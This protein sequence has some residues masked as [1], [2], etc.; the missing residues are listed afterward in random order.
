MKR[1]ELPD[2]YTAA[3]YVVDAC[4]LYSRVLRDCLLY[5]A[6]ANLI[7]VV[8][9]EVILEEMTE[10]LMVNR[11]G[12]TQES[13]DHLARAMNT[14]YP[15]AQRNPAAADFEALAGIVLPDED[16]R[17]VI[18]TALG[19]PASFVCTHNVSDFPTDVMGR[20]N[21]T[22]LTPDDLLCPLIRDHEASM[23]WVHRTSVGSLPGVTDESTIA[24]LRK[25]GAP[26]TADLIAERLGLA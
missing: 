21:L 23:V 5:A 13:A 24:A 6:R 9:S 11:P 26:K 12:F 19:A 20:L 15:Y 3:T 25:A 4:V 18:A 14:A 17:H 22:V 2:S 8:W 16:D 10:H 1:P 7:R